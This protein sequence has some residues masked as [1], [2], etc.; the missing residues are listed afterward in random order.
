MWQAGAPKDV[1]GNFFRHTAI[2]EQVKNGVS[3]AQNVAETG[4]PLW[5]CP[6]LGGIKK[7]EEEA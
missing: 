2:H 6:G 7:I 1:G 3:F 4:R 5:P